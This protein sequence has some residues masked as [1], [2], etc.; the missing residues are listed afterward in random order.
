M[1]WS[2]RRSVVIHQGHAFDSVSHNLLSFQTKRNLS[3]CLL[4]ILSLDARRTPGLRLLTVSLCLRCLFARPA[5]QTTLMKIPAWT[6]T[7]AIR[8]FLLRLA[9]AVT[10]SRRCHLAA[11]GARE[12]PLPLQRIRKVSYIMEMDKVA[13]SLDCIAEIRMYSSSEDPKRQFYAPSLYQT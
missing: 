1:H 11:T 7:E 2:A 3:A 5:V 9:A 4:F 6:C 12:R 10:A 13:P 8:F